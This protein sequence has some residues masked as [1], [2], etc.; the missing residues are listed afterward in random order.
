MFQPDRIHPLRQRPA[1]HARQ[2]L[3]G[4]RAAAAI[5]AARTRDG[6]V[7]SAHP[8]ARPASIRAAFA[9]LL[10]LRTA[11]PRLARPEALRRVAA[12]RPVRPVAAP[13]RRRQRARRLGGAR[14]RRRALARRGRLHAANRRC[15]A[16]HVRRRAL[17]R[18]PGGPA[19]AL[20]HPAARR[21][22]PAPAMPCRDRSLPHRCS[23]G[24]R[25]KAPRGGRAEARR[26]L[27]PA[28]TPA[29]ERASGRSRP[30]AA[31]RPA[32]RRRA[33][34][35]SPGRSRR[36]R[37]RAGASW[38][39]DAV[40]AR[41]SAGPR[42]DAV[43]GRSPM[44]RR[45]A[46]RA[47]RRCDR[48]PLG[49]PLTDAIA[50]T[51]SGP[52]AD[53]ITGTLSGPLADAITGTLAVGRSPRP[54]RS[55]RPP[56]ERPCVGPAVD[57]TRAGRPAKP[58][59]ARPSNGGRARRLARDAVGVEPR[60]CHGRRHGR[61]ERAAVGNHRADLGVVAEPARE[62]RDRLAVR[63]DTLAGTTVTACGNLRFAKSRRS[64]SLPVAPVVSI[65][66]TLVTCVTL[67]L[68]T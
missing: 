44:R 36:R 38:G 67:M 61:A 6:R 13:R 26:R 23:A 31:P 37:A 27:S 18:A 49:G 47:A 3:A 43:A 46:Q 12:P 42:A 66:V 48:R 21:A 5:A 53:A 9:P 52:L 68:R 59:G 54:G 2:R 40:A 57:A 8:L 65:T 34:V 32:H 50:G 29:A 41:R 10:R 25:P 39:A 45:H 63:S 51:L 4:A 62:R 55:S 22:A 30:P 1:G 24:S 14:R 15:R 19:A 58:P 64:A 7:V 28:R 56:S 17:L 16:G 33:R 11:H 35:R 60:P 20:P